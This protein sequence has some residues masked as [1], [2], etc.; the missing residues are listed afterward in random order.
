VA[1][2]AEVAVDVIADGEKN[3]RKSDRLQ[4]STGARDPVGI[5]HHKSFPG[6]LGIV[7]V[8]RPLDE[9]DGVPRVALA[10]LER[11]LSGLRRETRAGT[12]RVS[13]LV[14]AVVVIGAQLIP[15]QVGVGAKVEGADPVAE[16]P[17]ELQGS[18]AAVE[19]LPLRLAEIGELVERAVG[20]EREVFL[21]QLDVAVQ[22]E[23]LF[24]ELR[25]V[26]GG[27][28]LRPDAHGHEKEN[29][30]PESPQP[31]HLRSSCTRGR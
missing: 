12:N 16:L 3:R 17:R 2:R 4:I 15:P 18:G 29:E 5:R 26:E 6:E 11:P 22:L 13:R 21:L 8:F 30:R 24:L 19:G 31:L 20:V 10:P 1:A 27:G 25:G 9:A 23:G 14:H 7:R 28:F